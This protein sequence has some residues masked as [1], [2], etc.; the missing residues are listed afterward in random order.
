MEIAWV[1]VGGSLLGQV[2]KM[3]QGAFGPDL[4]GLYM[5]N[6]AEAAILYEMTDETHHVKIGLRSPNT[7]VVEFV[8]DNG[9][10]VDETATHL[11]YAR[12]GGKNYLF[13]IVDGA[14]MMNIPLQALPE[15]RIALGKHEEIPEIDL[16][17][18]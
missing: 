11:C 2:E 1:D 7:V 6:K 9:K 5:E 18:L 16:D 12:S 14:W 10:R 15:L 17:Q 8:D 4:Y 3:E 13:D